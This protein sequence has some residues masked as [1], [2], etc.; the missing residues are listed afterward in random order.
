[1][2]A[3]SGQMLGPDA[4]GQVELRG[5]AGAVAATLNDLSEF[6]LSPV[7]PGSYTLALHLADAEIEVIG[8]EIGG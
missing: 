1:M 7:P 8:L 6:T 2:W 3:V 5:Q 4:S